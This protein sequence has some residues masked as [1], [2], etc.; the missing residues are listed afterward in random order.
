MSNGQIIVLAVLGW[1]LLLVFLDARCR[2]GNNR[3]RARDMARHPAAQHPDGDCDNPACCVSAE[4]S[5]AMVAA[6]AICVRSRVTSPSAPTTHSG[7]STGRVIAPGSR[8]RT[9]NTLTTAM[10]TIDTSTPTAVFKRRTP[11]ETGGQPR[12]PPH[13]RQSG[14]LRHP[15]RIPLLLT[16]GNALPALRGGEIPG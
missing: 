5:A 15:G 13:L 3:E 14:P 16:C 2:R 11:F 4:Q 6:L 10:R 7:P 1:W 9:T 12:Q 8:C